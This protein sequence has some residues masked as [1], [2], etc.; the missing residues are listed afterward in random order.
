MYVGVLELDV[1]LGQVDSLK[2]KRAVIR[3]IL[4]RL[5]RL[6]VSVTEAGDTDRLR[7]ALI[8]VATV[9]GDHAQVQRVLDSCERQ[10]AGE[11]EIELL[12]ARRRVIGAQDDE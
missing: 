5:R 1:L 2:Y 7:R 11:V 4:A 3:P 9:S 6:D 12:E 10:V 8:G